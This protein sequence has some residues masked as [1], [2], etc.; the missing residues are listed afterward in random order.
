MKFTQEAKQYEELVPFEK[1]Y[2][3]AMHWYALNYKVMELFGGRKKFEQLPV[4]EIGENSAIVT[5]KDVHRI[6][7]KYPCKNISESAIANSTRIMRGR[8]KNG[9][10]FFTLL[11]REI[12]DDGTKSDAEVQV[13]VQCPYNKWVCFASL[14]QFSANST[15]IENGTILSDFSFR[16]VAQLIKTGK[17]EDPNFSNRQVELVK[18]NQTK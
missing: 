13:F 16:V 15:L 18:N 2:H 14:L 8:D 10:E 12:C 1:Q 7:Q 17:V 3:E 4:L 6:W 9:H 5:F 11:A